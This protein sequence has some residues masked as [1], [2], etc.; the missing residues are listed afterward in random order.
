[1]ITG[2][3]TEKKVKQISTNTR[4]AIRLMCLD[5]STFHPGKVRNCKFTNC[6]LYP[7]RMG[8]SKQNPTQLNKAIRQYCTDCMSGCEGAIQICYSKNCP[9]HGFRGGIKHND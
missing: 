6:P 2:I 7:Y 1:M 5:C 8:T 9:L 4:K 3:L